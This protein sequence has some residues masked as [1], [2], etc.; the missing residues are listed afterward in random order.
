VE[1]KIGESLQG[2]RSL[3]EGYRPPLFDIG[4]LDA[5]Y[6]VGAQ[7]ALETMRQIVSAEG[8]VAGVSS[9]ATLYAATRYAE[10][11][12]RANIVV[13]FSDGGWKYLPA[14]PWEAVLTQDHKL[15]EIHWW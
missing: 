11:L 2:L 12:E 9:G 5:R 3:E 4:L 13:M 8:I 6:L 14:R 1:P 15:D 7:K 10:K